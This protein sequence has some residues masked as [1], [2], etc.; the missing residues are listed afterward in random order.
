M[1]FVAAREGMDPEFV[2]SEVRSHS[3][4]HTQHTQHTQQCVYRHCVYACREGMN[5]EYVR[6]EVRAHSAQKQL[7]CVLRVCCL[8][9]CCAVRCARCTSNPAMAG[10]IA[11][12][13]SPQVARSRA[14]MPPKKCHLPLQQLPALPTHLF[15]VTTC[16]FTGCARP[17]HHPGQQAPPG[18]RAD[19]HR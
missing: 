12:W 19:H 16:A 9:V 5:P 3:T 4:Q 1:A 7:V 6:S 15:A 13:Q 18:A 17:C 10:L 8:Y 2:R 14:I 11:I